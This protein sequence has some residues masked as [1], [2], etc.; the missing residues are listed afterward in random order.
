MSLA[1]QTVTVGTV[2]AEFLS[3]AQASQYTS[4]SASTLRRRIAS[5]ALPIYD[6]ADPESPQRTIRVRRSDLDALGRPVNLG[7]AA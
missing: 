7:G 1:Y 5:G 2:E 6:F 4:L 3:L